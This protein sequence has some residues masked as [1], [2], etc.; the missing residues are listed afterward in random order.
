MKIYKVGDSQKAAC[1]ICKAFVNTTFKLRNVPFS[2][3]SGIV[4]NVLAGVCD[5]CDNVILLPHQSTP[6]V[7]KQLNRQP[8]PI[9]SR[10]PAHMIDILNLVTLEIGGSTDFVPNLMKY[11]IHFLAGNAKLAQSISGYLKND[12]AIGK[13]EKRLSLKGRRIYDELNSLKVISQLPTTTDLLKC[14]I[15]KI[16]DDV[17]VKR[18]AKTIEQLKAIMAVVE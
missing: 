2:D 11:Y 15:L 8:K 18:K 6:M 5:Y 16:N 7:K 10:L 1:E 13:A 3:G 17:L 9:E 12:L 4:R 14:I